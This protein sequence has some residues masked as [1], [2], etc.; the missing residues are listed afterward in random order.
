VA[1]VPFAQRM[2]NWEGFVETYLPVAMHLPLA[3]P[4]FDSTLVAEG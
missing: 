3:L 2:W 1:V 4:N